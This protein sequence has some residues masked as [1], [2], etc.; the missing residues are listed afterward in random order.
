MSHAE[1]LAH[2][3]ASFTPHA[4]AYGRMG[5]ALRYVS[6]ISASCLRAQR[7]TVAGSSNVGL[8]NHANKAVA[9]L[10]MCSPAARALVAT[11]P[12]GQQG[13]P[14]THAD[15]SSALSYP[16][17]AP[18]VP[19]TIAPI[20]A[21]LRSVVCCVGHRSVTARPTLCRAAKCT[22]LAGLSGPPLHRL[23]R[24]LGGALLVR[25]PPGAL[26]WFDG[27]SPALNDSRHQQAPVS[28]KWRCAP[29]CAG[30]PFVTAQGGPVAHGLAFGLRVRG[31]LVGISSLL[32]FWRKEA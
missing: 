10:R 2:E 18:V 15:R 4:L 32:P 16:P 13:L 9:S 22:I 17:C 23:L 19:A 27:V 11:L 8:S 5:R 14:F 31:F 25:C 29:G 1:H 6:G 21:S 26:W 12:P 3:P 7:R 24:R 28:A 20:A 30:S